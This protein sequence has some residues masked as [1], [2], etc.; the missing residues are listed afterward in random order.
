MTSPLDFKYADR[1]ER[2][3]APIAAAVESEALPYCSVG[4]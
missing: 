2:P 4:R 1:L 3:A